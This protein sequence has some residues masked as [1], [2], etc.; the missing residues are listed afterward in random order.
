MDN[1][2]KVK[3]LCKKADIILQEI[4]WKDEM[5]ERR[6]GK[7]VA[8]LCKRN[9]SDVEIIYRD[10]EGKCI[11]VK[12]VI[13]GENVFV[14]NVHAQNAEAENKMFFNNLNGQ[15]EK[16]ENI[17][18]MGDFN[19][20]LSRLDI[21]NDMVYKR[22]SGREELLKVIDNYDLIDIYGERGMRV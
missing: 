9:M 5:M 12:M 2:G 1:F 16:W 8:V 11:I 7:G 4:F 15:M 20:V 13:R 19:T 3:E 17:I 18:L 6:N 21:A 22:D 10:N 14:C